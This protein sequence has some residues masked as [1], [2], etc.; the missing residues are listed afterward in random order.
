[1]VLTSSLIRPHFT[2]DLEN[3]FSRYGIL[4]WT[5]ERIFFRLRLSFRSFAEFMSLTSDL[6]VASPG[7][8]P[9][10][11]LYEES[12]YSIHSVALFGLI[13]FEFAVDGFSI[14]AEDACGLA[15]VAA[16]RF[17]YMGDVAAFKFFQ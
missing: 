9:H 11:N 8:S 7:Y 1:M 14:E 5:T 6:G 2:N 4:F 15:L 17:Q 16:G 13:L 10:T 12:L 3:Q